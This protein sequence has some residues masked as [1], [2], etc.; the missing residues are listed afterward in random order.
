[1]RNLARISAE[2]YL[3]QREEMGFPLLKKSGENRNG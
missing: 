1:V 2:G 3:K